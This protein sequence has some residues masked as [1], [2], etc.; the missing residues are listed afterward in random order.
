MITLQGQLAIKTIPGRYG[1]FNVGRL[2]TEIGEFVVKDALLEEYPEGKYDGEFDVKE[3]KPGTPYTSG[4]RLIIEIRAHLSGITLSNIDALSKDEAH[5]LSP[6]EVDPV[7]E[8]EDSK[9]QQP[10]VVEAQAATSSEPA[11]ET[12]QTTVEAESASAESEGDQS[13]NVDLFGALWPLAKV[14]KLDPTVDRRRF[15]QQRDRLSSMG[16]RF[17]PH[18]QDWHLAA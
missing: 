14:V 11:A 15:R 16:Y 6:Q 9:P 13:E 12:T 10:A 2:F 5:N 3:I 7:E 17:Q 18:S 1:K 4:G 8:E